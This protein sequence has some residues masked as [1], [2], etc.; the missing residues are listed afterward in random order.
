M[1]A[2]P[3]PSDYFLVAVSLLLNLQCADVSLQCTWATPLPI[4]SPGLSPGTLTLARGDK[5]HLLSM[6]PLS[7]GVTTAAEAVASPMASLDLSY[8]ASLCC[9]AWPL[10]AFKTSTVRET[11]KHKFG[12]Q[13][14]IQPC[15]LWTILFVHW[16]EENFH[17]PVMAHLSLSTNDF[18]SPKFQTLPQSFLKQHG[19]VCHS[20]SPVSVPVSFLLL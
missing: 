15:S 5:P 4:T 20:S 1:R 16:P 2:S 10:Y 17:T 13:H 3:L 7:T 18:S 14:E 8:G 12:C 19:Q 6:N 9:S 11:L